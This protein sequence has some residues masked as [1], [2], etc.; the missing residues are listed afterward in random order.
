MKTPRFFIL[1]GAFLL[2]SFALGSSLGS[3]VPLGHCQSLLIPRAA[4]LAGDPDE[5]GFS[6]SIPFDDEG[7]YGRT[8]TTLETNSVKTAGRRLIQKRLLTWFL[9]LHLQFAVRR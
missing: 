8:A 9:N 5:P 7:S 2:L 1:V 4:P 3:M 6:K